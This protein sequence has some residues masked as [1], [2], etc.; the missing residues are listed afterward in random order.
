MSRSI[1]SVEKLGSGYQTISI[2]G[3][4]AVRVSV[5]VDCIPARHSKTCLELHTCNNDLYKQLIPCSCTLMFWSFH[6]RT[7]RTASL[8]CLIFF[9]FWQVQSCLWRAIITFNVFLWKFSKEFSTNPWCKETHQN[10]CAVFFCVL[11][12]GCAPLYTAV[13]AII[14]HFN[15]LEDT[16]STL[17]CF[18]RQLA[19]LIFPQLRITGVYLIT[20]F[21]FFL[22]CCYFLSCYHY[23]A[24]KI[25]QQ[26]AE[27][28]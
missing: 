16:Y 20:Y 3:K 6:I 27:I 12:T 26:Y 4:L 13:T 14:Y 7:Q 17:Y 2:N 15:F 23:A 8:W 28:A 11:T 19:A 10:S 18:I 25:F 9:I 24:N 5:P 22:F 1:F 21:S